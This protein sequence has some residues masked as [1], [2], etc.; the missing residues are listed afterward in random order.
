MFTAA[1]PPSTAAR[2]AITAFAAPA[3]VRADSSFAIRF[4]IASEALQPAHAE[5][6]LLADGAVVGGREI[7]LAPGLNRFALPY[8]I[9]RPGAYLIKAQIAVAAPLT[10]VA[11]AAETAGSVSA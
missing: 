4:D 2:V 1:P 3:A 5:L 10:A 7:T 8:R 11:P 6:T 9:A